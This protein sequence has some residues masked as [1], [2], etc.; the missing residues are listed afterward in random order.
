MAQQV[1]AGDGKSKKFCYKDCTDVE[2]KRI[3]DGKD[4]RNTQRATERAVEQLKCYLKVKNLP[5]LDV[6]TD[7]ELANILSDFYP[8]VQ[9]QKQDQDCSVQSLKC[10]RADLNR[11]FKTTRNL[12][13]INDDRFIGCNE[14]FRGVCVEAKHKGRGVKHS[15]PPISDEDM[16]QIGVFFN[17][18]HMQNPDQRVLQKQIIFYIIYFFCRRGRENLNEM[19]RDTFK[20]D[21]DVSDGLEYVVQSIDEVDKNHGPDDNT[22][23]NEGKMYADPSK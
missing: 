22:P 5:D 11:Y 21:V 8:A 1:D 17:K 18:D 20:I 13:I 7:T 4:K 3:L 10:L 12:N 6:T 23:T 2:K 19:T 16:F 9:P 15:Y 14:M